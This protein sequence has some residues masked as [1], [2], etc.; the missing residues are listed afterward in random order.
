MKRTILIACVVMSAACAKRVVTAPLEGYVL[1]GDQR[2]SY[3]DWS[4][5]ADLCAYDPKL[6]SKDFESMNTLLTLFLEQT[7]GDATAAWDEPKLDLYEKGVK[8]LPTALDLEARSLQAAKNAKCQFEGVAKAAELNGKARA[9][10]EEGP[11]IIA[12]VRAKRALAGWKAS[13]PDMMNQGKAAKCVVNNA[14]PPPGKAKPAKPAVAEPIVYGAFE[15]ETGHAEWHFCDGAKVV[16]AAAGTAPAFEAAPAPPEPPNA[17]KAKK[18]APAPA[19]QPW[20]DAAA[21]YPADQIAHAP[22]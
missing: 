15:D 7:Q 14:P 5:T 9:R 12:A 4:K 17:K 20:L 3:R 10:V 16:V 11:A 22:K 19:P 18:P 13:V 1:L 2:A 6:V 21:K 8:Q